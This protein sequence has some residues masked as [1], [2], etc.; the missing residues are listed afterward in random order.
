MS[1][2]NMYSPDF[3]VQHMNIKL[4]NTNAVLNKSFTKDQRI[5]AT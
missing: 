4:A 2:A 5:P 3:K 1:N